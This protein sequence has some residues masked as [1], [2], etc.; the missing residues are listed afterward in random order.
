MELSPEKELFETVAAVPRPLELGVDTNAR[1]R[2]YVILAI[3]GLALALRLYGINTY[4]LF[5][6]EYNSIAGAQ[7]INLNWNSILYAVL[8][9]FLIRLG[10]T[11]FWLRLPAMIFGAAAVPILFRIGERIGGWRCAV[12][13]GLLAAAS[14]FN[15]FHSQEMRFYSLF[16]LASATFLL[17]TI[18]YLDRPRSFGGRLLLLLAGIFLVLSH[19]L[20]VLALCAQSTAALFANS[21]V[22]KRFRTAVLAGFAL[23]IGVP[24]IPFV[25]HKLW[26]FYSAHAGVTDFSLPPFN[27]LSIVNFAKLGFALFTFAFGYHVYPLRVGFVMFG[28]AVFGFLFCAGLLSLWK[29]SEWRML[30]VTYFLALIAVFFV[31]NSIGG[32]V[33]SVIGPRHVAFAW[34]VFILLTGMGVAAFGQKMFAVLLTTVMLLSAGALWLGWQKDWSPGNVP[35]YR[36]AATYATQWNDDQT[37]LIVMGRSDGPF[38]FYFPKNLR[39]GDWYS[40]LQ[41]EDAAPLRSNRRL[42]IVSDEWSLDRRQG[43]DR[44]LRQITENYTALD[45]R[46]DYPLFE[47]VFDRNPRVENSLANG[48]PRQLQFPL[49]VYGLEFQDL[50]LPV[51]VTAKATSMKVIGASALPNLDDEKL[52]SVSLSQLKPAQE[53]VLLSNVTGQSLPAPGTV[54]AE[55]LIE[56]KAGLITTLPIRMGMETASWDQSCQPSANCKT[57]FQWHKRLAIVGQN[58]YPGAW[59]DFVGQMHAASFDL[60]QPTEVARVSIRY[61]AEGGHLYIWGAVLT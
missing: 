12:A 46:V 38:G 35:D 60:Q 24:L 27:G 51:N 54:V 59:R 20:G 13:C 36:T 5:G 28:S 42:I 40:Y 50:K 44:T 47:Y 26:D 52:M 41:T 29:K 34:P 48:P 1:R 31:L 37:A 33:S 32:R 43:I 56:D 61:R 10:D 53:L 58:S 3:V 7:D 55:L 6:D 15:I 45:G 2:M 14:P 8:T 25:Q 9:H 23:L 4:P 18:N 39:T 11:E 21:T 17:C 19:F 22:P 57:A 49:S 16:I 30:P